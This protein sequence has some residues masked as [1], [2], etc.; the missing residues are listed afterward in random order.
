[1]SAS[2]Q[3]NLESLIR[4]INEE[5]D[6]EHLTNLLAQ[7]E[8]YL[9]KI[10]ELRPPYNPLQTNVL[11]ITMMHLST[12]CHKQ[13]A[14]LEKTCVLL[15]SGISNCILQSTISTFMP[16]TMEQWTPDPPK[17]NSNNRKTPSKKSRKETTKP[18]GPDTDVLEKVMIDSGIKEPEQSN[19][20]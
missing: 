19:Y 17:S 3:S 1:M 12:I 9:D 16:V 15:Q 5:F 7:F 18:K 14:A 13:K 2:T 8:H 11:L 6:P 10:K 20:D 4:T